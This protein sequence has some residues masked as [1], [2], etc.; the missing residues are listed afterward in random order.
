MYKVLLKYTK[1]IQAV[2]CDEAF[3]EFSNIS[4]PISIVQQIRNEIYGNSI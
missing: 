1:K 3:L 2:S 4:D